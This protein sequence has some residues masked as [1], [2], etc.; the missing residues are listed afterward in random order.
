MG[1][2]GS[3]KSTIARLLEARLG[4]P[5]QEGDDLH[6]ATNVAK[7]AAGIPLDDADRAPWVAAV[8]AWIHDRQ[9][10]GESGIVTCSALRRR[11]RDALRGDH[12][13]FVYLA[14]PQ[15]VIGERLAQRAGHFMSPALLGSQLETLEPP[16]ADEASLTIDATATPQQQ[17]ESILEQLG[18]GLDG[19]RAQ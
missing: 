2:S 10:A 9:A 14:G 6:P 7:L 16:A 18:L 11:Y 5:F 4:W 12:V 17:V 15:D 13:V 8:A 3:G 19:Q 1:V